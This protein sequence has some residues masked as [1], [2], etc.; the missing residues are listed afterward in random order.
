MVKRIGLVGCGPRG[1]SLFER[2]LSVAES[3]PEQHIEIHV[4]E[5]NIP[6]TGVHSISQPKYLLLN[7]V[8]G[9]LSAYPDKVALDGL[10]NAIERTGPDFLQWCQQND[11]RVDVVSKQVSKTGR[12][13]QQ[14][15]FLPRWLLGLYL[16]EC[17]DHL[18]NSATA[19]VTVSVHRELVASVD[20]VEMNGPYV[21]KN[22]KGKGIE[23]DALILA[24]GHTGRQGV[25]SANIYPLP[26]TV[27]HIPAGKP[28]LVKGMGLGSMDAITA[29]TVG[30]GGHFV[31][32]SDGNCQYVACGNE[33]I[34]Y[35]QS[36]DGLPYKARPNGLAS[37]P[38]Y[39]PIV[40]N[41]RMVN[42]LRESCPSGRLNFEKDI[43][44]LLKLEIRAA[45]VSIAL[46]KGNADKRHEVLTSLRSIV[47]CNPT[48][49][50]L[51]V[52][53]R[54]EAL[55]QNIGTI[56][57]E[58]LLSQKLPEDVDASTY[59]DWICSSMAVDLQEAQRGVSLSSQKAAAEVLRDLRD[60]LREII[61]FD[62]L[63]E[64]SQKVFYGPWY[65]L[66]N[67]LVAGPQK[68]RIAEL[69]A[70]KSAGLLTFL[71]PSVQCKDVGKR[72]LDAYVSSSGVE[73]SASGLVQQ[74]NESGVVKG[75]RGIPGFDAVDV[76]ENYNAINKFGD[77]QRHLWVLGPLTEGACYY[78]HYVASG[79][80][81]SK[82]FIDAHRI[83]LSA[84]AFN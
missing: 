63:T 42:Y 59:E 20:I 81:P 52:I 48:G 57:V 55:E 56:D 36:R 74:L 9:Q 50:L 71:H 68:E 78:N 80:A 11:I 58:T 15:D 8:A 40:L 23:V 53:E 47:N 21:L 72:V 33:P 5:P 25:S 64:E 14:D 45:A 35:I 37:Y 61:D 51:Q 75:R 28:L 83:A 54:L 82:Y 39:K 69:L 12:L 6:G 10:P 7:T 76:D 62:G 44:P 84:I 29:L 18:K 38:R 41:I 49:D 65:K 66:I 1:L 31:H 70:L 46:S 2:I 34:L 43:L 16:S 77:V 17:F 26:E 19:N 24:L 30:N 13:V 67:R 27:M 3:M 79:G 60:V 32:S 4:F 22:V 73:N